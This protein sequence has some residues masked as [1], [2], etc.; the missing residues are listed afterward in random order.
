MTVSLIACI[1]EDGALNGFKPSSLDRNFFKAMTLASSPDDLWDTFSYL[2]ESSCEDTTAFL[3]ESAHVSL[4]ALKEGKAQN[5]VLIGRKTWEDTGWWGLAKKTLPGRHTL[6][7]MRNPCI[8][9]GVHC[10]WSIAGAKG[11]CDYVQ[12]PHLWIAGGAQ[13]Y[14]LALQCAELTT[15]YIT[16]IA[17][18][19]IEEGDNPTFPWP[20]KAWQQTAETPWLLDREGQRLRFMQWKKH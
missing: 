10:V 11:F 12:S 5:T 14:T 1:A 16:E 20:H 6:V 19:P 4:Q 9:R 18:I 15:T 17:T 3:K 2:A 8:T 13:I 7:M